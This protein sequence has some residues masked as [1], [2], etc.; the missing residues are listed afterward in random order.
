MFYNK[1]YKYS[2]INYLL[3]IK[4]KFIAVVFLSFIFITF[5]VLKITKKIRNYSKGKRFVENCIVEKELQKHDDVYNSPIFSIIIPA[6]NC[7]KTIFYPIISIQHQNISQIEIILI[8]DFSNDNT[9]EVIQ[10]MNIYDKRIK[11]INNKKN[12]GTLYSRCLATLMSKGEYIFALDDDDMIFGDDIFDSLYK[13]IIEDNYDILA[14]KAV[15]SK[16][17]SEKIRKIKDSYSYNFPNNLIVHQPELSTWFILSNGEY[18]PHDVTLW[19]KIIK[20]S[21]YTE[22]I[23]LLGKERYSNF[24]SWAEDTSM[25]YI[26]FNIA[27]SFK[28][29]HMYGILHLISSSTASITQ[30]INNKFFG[31]LFLIDIIFDFSKNTEDKKYSAFAALYTM[32]IYYKY[33][34]TINKS[35]LTYF[36]SIVLKIIN[37]KHICIDIKYKLSLS[38]GNFLSRN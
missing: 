3:I 1:E 35:N 8:N 29:I 25:N 9:S 6:Y 16:S 7:E 23:N 30:P 31:E 20:T 5:F 17:Y 32:K 36:N 33:K 34:S 22:A 28:F 19:G 24:V 14:F 27:K 37:S 18:N 2:T 21:I 38:F 13:N 15:N 4:L 26:I 10:E 11:V 12:F